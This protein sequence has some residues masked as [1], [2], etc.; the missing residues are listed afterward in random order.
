MKAYENDLGPLD[1]TFRWPYKKERKDGRPEVL[2]GGRHCP[3]SREFDDLQWAGRWG[4]LRGVDVPYF[5]HATIPVNATDEFLKE[6]RWD[7][8]PYNRDRFDSD[9][10]R[11]LRAQPDWHFL[12]RIFHLGNNLPP[13]LRFTLDIGDPEKI[14]FAKEVRHLWDS[15]SIKTTVRRHLVTDEIVRVESS[16]SCGTSK[17]IVDACAFDENLYITFYSGSERYPCFGERPTDAYIAK[18]RKRT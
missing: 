8:P 9:D 15:L 2:S 16:S 1:L 6:R 14:A 12:P 4:R 3:A 17:R 10:L 13:A 11:K 7:R 18:A 5:A